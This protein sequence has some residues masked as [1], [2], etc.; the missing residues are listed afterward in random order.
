[1][2]IIIYISMRRN[3]ITRQF[4]VQQQYKVALLTNILPT[5]VTML[6]CSGWLTVTKGEFVML[7]CE[8]M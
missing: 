8:N 2:Y 7:L 3:L 1:M 6:G 4:A 5:T